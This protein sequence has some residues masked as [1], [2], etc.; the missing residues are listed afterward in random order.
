MIF[1]KNQSSDHL[2]SL[3]C[4]VGWVPEGNRISV[5]GITVGHVRAHQKN[6]L[7]CRSIKW[8]GILVNDSLSITS[9][10]SAGLE[11]TKRE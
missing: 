6:A 2:V 4:G 11:T 5:S 8:E 7:N 3:G 9:L 1:T 10:K